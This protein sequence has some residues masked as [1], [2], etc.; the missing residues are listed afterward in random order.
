[1][2]TKSIFYPSIPIKPSASKCAQTLVAFMGDVIR[3][4]VGERCLFG[5][6]LPSL[7]QCYQRIKFRTVFQSRGDAENGDQKNFTILS[8]VYDT[9]HMTFSIFSPLF[10]DAVNCCNC[11]ISII[12]E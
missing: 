7:F 11:I 9:V 3:V 4:S 2:E 5:K 8:I 12:G 6:Y 10:K 1:M